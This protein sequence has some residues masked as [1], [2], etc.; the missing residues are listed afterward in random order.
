[1]SSATGYA[2]AALES[3]NRTTVLN[4]ALHGWRLIRTSNVALLSTIALLVIAVAAILAP[5]IAPYSPVAMSPDTLTAPNVHHFFGTDQ[6]GRDMLSRVLWGARLTLLSAIVGV[7]I[8]TGIGVPLGLLAGYSTRWVSFVIM[9]AMDVLL[10]FPGLMLALLIV[11]IIG[12]GLVSVMVAIGISFIPVFAR[13]VYGSTLT[14]KEL[15]Y[16]L[17][18]R[19]TG[20]GP[21]HIMAREILP[22]VVTQI[23]VI[24]SSAIGWAILTGTTLNFLGF[25]VQ[26]PTPEWGADLAAGRDWLRVA[27][28]VSAFPGLAITV[29]ILAANYLGDHLAAILEPRARL[30]LTVGRIGAGE[31]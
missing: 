8:A 14:A 20:C 17:A 19:A 31:A 6:F 18:A 11:T 3:E 5:L 4:R 22:N 7:A 24:V 13:V 29:T 16:V 10:A 12:A 25:G 30:T 28:W 26:L 9:R 27:W 2:D 15:D 21:L 1:M 23:I